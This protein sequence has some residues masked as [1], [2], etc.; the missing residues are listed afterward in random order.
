MTLWKT[1][2]LFFTEKETLYF[3]V[4]EIAQNL[5]DIIEKNFPVLW[6][7]GEIANLRYSH[8][9]NV[10][11]NLIDEE[12]SLKA[13][14]F[15]SQKDVLYTSALKN[16]VQVLCLG[17]LN[18]YPKTGECFFIV[19][20]LEPVGRGYLILKKEALIKKYSSF[21]DPNR[22][23]ELPR[24]PKKIALVTSLFGAALRDFLKISADRWE[25]EILVYPVRVQGEGAEVEIVQAIKDIN[26][27]FKDVEVIVITR[28]GGAFEDLAP[29]YTEE[30]ILGIK[31]SK[32]PVVSAVGH[33]IDYTICDL[34]ADKRCPTPSAAAQEVI[35]DK[36]KVLSELNLYKKKFL[37]I[38]EHRLSQKE[39][40]LLQI[41][42]KIEEK[43]PFKLLHQVENR[44]RNYT[45]FF[46]LAMEK[47]FSKKEKELLYYKE[48][49]KK[50]HPLQKIKIQ[51]EKLTDL[52]HRLIQAFRKFL[53]K[54]EREIQAHL[55]VLESL[56]PMRVL[57]RGYSIVKKVE[58]QEVIKSV[59]NLSK[60][61]L[62]EIYF[63][64]GKIIA[65]VKDLIESFAK[66]RG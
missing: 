30:I 16:G 62:L 56:S 3:K 14:I 1:Q 42:W 33:E 34:I 26:E 20:R 57:E 47:F 59:K 11:F 58:T 53:E 43:N 18:F 17:R 28:G 10:Y 40:R 21:F 31:D 19:R 51:E 54:K 5:K 65:E 36:L 6:I 12:A 37:Q 25:I 32:I 29:F 38:V 55:K 48:N 45:H 60:G 39:R 15:N 2:S 63:S 41:K 61:D 23:K 64:E 46:N 4:K 8:S 24:F 22:K 9:G 52:K 7:E 66:E 35:P 49:L 44:L 50:H 13:I 27:Y